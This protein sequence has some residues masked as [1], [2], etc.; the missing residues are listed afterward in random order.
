MWLTT[1]SVIYLCFFFFFFSPVLLRYTGQW[2]SDIPCFGFYWTEYYFRSPCSYFYILLS[3]LKIHSAEGRVKGFSACTFELT[4]MSIF[5]GTMLFMWEKAMAPHFST[6]A[7]K[8]PWTEEPRRL[9]SM[10]SLGVGGDWVTSLSLFTF[11]HWRR[12]WR[13]TPVFLPGESQG[14]RGLVGCRIWGRT[15][16]DATEVT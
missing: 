13:P 8:I 7:W 12:R 1:F 14:W 16:S 6:L 15:E 3:V 11:M 9:Q 5:Q 2:I 4:A 10:G